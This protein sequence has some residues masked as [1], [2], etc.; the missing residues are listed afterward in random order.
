MAKCIQVSCIIL[1]LLSALFGADS[2]RIYV[3]NNKGTNIHVIDP[4]TNKVVQIIEG[5][6]D[7]HGA[8]FSPDGRRTYITSE[9]ENALYEVDTSSGKTLR[10]LDELSKGTANLPAITRDGGKLFICINGLRDAYGHMQS[11]RGGFVDVVDTK[12]MKRTKS[13]PRRG[14]MHDCYITPDG[15]YVLAS[16]LGGKFLEVIDVK[17]EEPLWEVTFDKGVTTTAQELNPDGSTRRLFSNLTDFRGFAVIDFAQRKEVARIQLPDEPSGVTLGEKLRRR[18]RI[19]TH[20]NEVSPDGKTLW[21]VSRGANG[22]F[23]YSLPD[24]K[25][26]NF[27]PTPRLK[28]APDGADGGDPGWITFT[29]DGKTVYISNAMLNTVTAIDAKK[30]VPIAEIPV[31]EQPDHVFT[32]KLPKKK[33]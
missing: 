19:P 18:N 13:I 28:N 3:L 9:S 21:V 1:F 29:P 24:L 12:T 27:V 33:K 16:T 4:S 6:P 22:V 20:G 32:L 26:I 31:G 2:G 30:M 15:K 11:Q 10:K 14:G 7:P 23:V 8:A 17:T 25:V 5:I